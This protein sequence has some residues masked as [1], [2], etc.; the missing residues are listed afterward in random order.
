MLSSMLAQAQST[1][2]FTPRELDKSFY[3][4][5]G[6]NRSF[7]RPSDIH[8]KGEDFDFTLYDVEADDDPEEFDAKVYLNPLKFTIPQFNF[9]LGY[10]IKE[11]LSISMGW[12]HMKYIITVPQTVDI[13]GYIDPSLSDEYG[14]EYFN[15]PLALRQNFVRYEHSDGLNY[16]RFGIEKHAPFIGKRS[17]KFKIDVLMSASA[18][19]MLPW[20]DFRFLDV[21]Y[22]NKPHLS[23]WAVSGMIAPRLRWKNTFF[24]QWQAQYGYIRMGDI[25]LQDHLESRASQSIWFNETSISLGANLPIY[26]RRNSKTSE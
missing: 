25:L 7:Y 10:Y 18:G 13:D 20:T 16:V 26:W 3:V 21:R 6:Y 23:G 9:R 22:R 12:D 11:N 2:V 1:E 17:N 14:G 24:V 5:W 15:E 4:T 8:F 19:Y